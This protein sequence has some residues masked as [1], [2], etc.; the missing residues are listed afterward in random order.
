MVWIGFIVLDVWG[1]MFLRKFY[2]YSIYLNWR[3]VIYGDGI[4]KYFDYWENFR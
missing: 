3:F 2:F 1:F 4:I